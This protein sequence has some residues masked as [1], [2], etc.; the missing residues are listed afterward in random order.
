MKKSKMIICLAVLAI[1]AS[2]VSLGVSYYAIV[3]AERSLDSIERRILSHNGDIKFE[4]EV[5]DFA[6]DTV[7]LNMFDIRERFER[8]LLSNVY[9]H[10][11]TMLLLKRST[12]WFP[13]IEPILAKYGIP[14]DFKYLCV[15]ESSLTNAVSPAGATGFWQFMEKTG[16]HYGLT[17]NNEVDMRYN[18]ELETEAACKYL[19]DSYEKFGNW[20]LVAASFNAGMR[21]VEKFMKA[22]KS[23]NYYDLLMNSETERYVFRILAVKTIFRNPE[24][25]GLF[26]SKTYKPFKYTT[27]TVDYDVDD[28]AEFAIS[29][30]I[31]YKLLKVFNP[32]LRKS[33]LKVKKGTGYE[34][35]IPV[36][37]FDLTY[38]DCAQ[39]HGWD[40]DTLMFCDSIRCDTAMICD[41]LMAENIL[42]TVYN[43]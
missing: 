37:P 17:I 11:S 35:K 10:S 28:W 23:D 12:R 18:V 41:T 1:L 2:T 22:Q 16:K 13:V 31:T 33:Y 26:V 5:I 3:V 27:V 30:G 36:K 19:R 8:E 21:G 38:E 42:D 43:Q 7:P 32:W 9:Y 25:Y 34:V 39:M 6:G 15:I 14:D 40:F 24:R 29:H 20:T 4:G